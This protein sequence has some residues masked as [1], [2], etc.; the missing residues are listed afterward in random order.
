MTAIFDYLNPYAYAMRLRRW[1]YERGLLKASHPGVPVI[2][3]GNLSLGGTGKSPMVLLVAHY[4]TQKRQRRVAI[5]SRGYKR[6]SK[7]LV[8]VSDARRI[9][10]SIED[11]GDEAQM[12]AQSLPGTIVIVSEDRL[13]GALEAKRLGANVI[14]LDDGFQHQRLQR[15]LDIV[16]IDA[17]R[18]L[19]AV[20]PFGRFREPFSAVRAAGAI[21][22]TNASDKSR[23]RDYWE[24]L[25][26]YANTNV[27]VAAIHAIPIAL[28]SLRD[29]EQLPLAAIRAKRV[30]ALSGIAS[31]ARFHRMLES[32]GA[33]VISR[34]LGDHAEYSQALAR[35]LVSDAERSGAQLLVTTMKDA[36]KSRGY[37][38][39]SSLPVLVLKQ[40]L[41]FLSGEQSLY[42]SIDRIL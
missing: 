25:K 26:P 1:F 8:V 40:E 23:L 33:E 30:L 35:S 11:S 22:F 14:L 27:V 37:F 28:E 39:Q 42:D 32:L 6:R 29:G 3:V 18:P 7:G 16:L 4:L 24:R 9:L 12:L 20:I 34:S 19:S 36:V 5:V 41:E 10:A 21:A 31:P 13:R 38:G 15:D 2:S 17:E